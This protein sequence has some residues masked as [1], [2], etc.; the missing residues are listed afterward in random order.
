MFGLFGKNSGLKRIE[1]SLRAAEDELGV[2]EAIF[3]NVQAVMVTDA[4]RRILRVN[5]AFCQL[6]G[7]SPAEVVGKTPWMFRSNHHDAVF[8]AAMLRS[9]GET[10]RWAGEIWDRRKDGRVFPKWMTIIAVKNTLGEL[11]HFVA[12]YV[13]LS[14]RKET[15]AQLR[16]L[17]LYDVLTKLPNRDLLLERLQ[18]TL[19]D[20]QRSGRHGA[21]LML[22]VDGFK[23]YNDAQGY[24]AGDE[25][26]RQIARRM[27]DH[28]PRN[29]TLARLSGDDFGILL[30]ELSGVRLKA[31]ALAG[32]LAERLNHALLQDLSGYQARTSIGLVI[33][34]PSAEGQQASARERLHDV[35]MAMYQAKRQGGGR[36]QFF[37]DS[38]RQSVSE[39]A[40]L[41]RELRQGI[42]AGQ[43]ELYY[44]PQIEHRDG[45]D[46]CTGAEALVRWNHPERGLMSPGVFIPLAEETGLILP[47]GQWVLEQACRQLADWQTDLRLAGVRL[48]VN[49]SAAQFLQD[50]FIDRLKALLVQSG[51]PARQLKLELTESLLL[52]RPAEVIESMQM[53]RA[54]GVKFSLDD[55]G[56]GYSSLAYLKRLPLD[57]LK[58]DQS[59]VRDMETDPND[60]VIARSVVALAQ[61][62]GLEVIAE[63]VETLAQREALVGMGCL[64]W[65]GYYFSR[66]LPLADFEQ[67]HRQKG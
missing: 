51:F 25:M 42:D 8:Y 27:G 60:L 40:I 39:R 3:A 59:F 13:D 22:D 34:S 47:L 58:I 49:L 16:Q 23:G 29:A 64:N 41:E 33:L 62:L 54:L 31:A 61:A 5:A 63:G 12:T 45:Q 11:H 66:P 56:T 10:G 46:I 14:E 55:F 30:P 37:D 24:H 43:L 67:F 52:D 1:D 18:Q 17:A 20:T 38:L 44:Q 21:L 19:G 15:E 50:G 2:A 28:L 53:L 4:R 7:Y 6:M 32:S 57:Q 36:L 9:V 65:Q 35:E 26:L 48:A